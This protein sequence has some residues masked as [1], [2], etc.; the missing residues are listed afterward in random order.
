MRCLL[1][2][3][4]L[5][6]GIAFAQTGPAG[7]WE[8]SLKLPDRE[9]PI[10]VDLAKD[11]KGAWIGALS[12]KAQNVANVPLAD[13]KVQDKS[14]KFRVSAGGPSAPS[15]DCTQESAAVLQCALTGPGGSLDATLKR[16]GEAKVEL[17]KASPAVS[18]E[19]EGN[20]EGAVET[21]NGSLRLVVHFQNQPDKTVKATMDSLDQN[22]T[23]LPLSDIV[24]TGAAVEFQL[25][26]V[27]GSY[28][29][30]MN[31]EAT[32]IA[33]DWSQSGATLPL[34]LKKSAAK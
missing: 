29:G 34:L 33:G 21:P 30:T 11:E 9:V 17:P 5:P 6:C 1:R 24:Q 15:F 20:W 26:L 4:L 27:N 3:A 18:A 23:D 2:L 32:Q 28:K 13:I 12:Q 25:R 8:G 10:S 19:L 16:T 14:V 31:K 22:S 7:H